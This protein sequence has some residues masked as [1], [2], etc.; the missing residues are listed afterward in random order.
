M[1][2]LRSHVYC[3]LSRR[4]VALGGLG[5]IVSFTFDDFPRS[6]LTV[7]GAILER[8]GAR[9]T[10]YVAM[11][12]MGKSNSLG[13]QFVC[14]DLQSLIERGHEVASHTYDHLSSRKTPMETFLE[15]VQR[16]EGAIRR[17]GDVE[18]SGNFAYPYGEVTL[19]AKKLLGPRMK[20]SRGTVGGFNGPEVDLNF[21]RANSLYGDADQS[22][23]A[24]KLILKNTE[25]RTWLI[26]YSHD[27]SHNPSAFGC[28][29]ALLE[30]V[31]SFAAE[32]GTRIMTVADVVSQICGRA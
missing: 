14:R 31:V 4:T 26:F 24:K 29:P 7:G 12:L 27:V 21:L 3:S 9:A 8:F 15:D 20:S 32:R 2:K 25:R 17:T 10:Y 6:A 16:G 13:E 30:E 11:G 5:P 19:Q 23:S 1:G 18:P 22:D 28:T